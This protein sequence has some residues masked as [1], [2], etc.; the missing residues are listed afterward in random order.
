MEGT[1]GYRSIMT[2]YL[3]MNPKTG[4]I[5]IT[6]ASKKGVSQIKLLDPYSYKSGAL[7]FTSSDIGYEKVTNPA[8]KSTAE[9]AW[10]YVRGIDFG[11]GASEFIGEVKGKGRIEVRL[12]DISSEPA[13]F[14]EFDCSD[15]TRIRS[16]G[17]AEFEGRNHNVY[18]V[19]SNTDIE[20]KSWRFTKG[21]TALRP[22]EEIAATDIP[23]KTLVL[24]GQAENPGPSPSA[25]L[26]ASKNGDYSVKTSSFDGNSEIINL[27]FINTDAEAKYKVYVK[28]LSLETE[29]GEVEVPVN[30]YLNPASE[31]ENGLE[32][33]WKGAEIGSLIYGTHELG[34][35][36]AESGIEWVGYR[37][38][39]KVSGE[40]VPFTS[41][42][43]NVTISGLDLVS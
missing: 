43:Y 33:G 1:E 4:E 16:D 3:P 35:F 21:E 24:T 20:L 12:D 13:A 25:I 17:F 11:Y 5:P 26:E 42:T 31:S 18:F 14:I 27:G 30:V 39:L 29:N 19:F 7:M 32:N 38:A 40:E 15:Y 36:A 37:L 34:I 23:F 28:S 9:G 22:E 6:A 2:E 10:I 41:I 8:A